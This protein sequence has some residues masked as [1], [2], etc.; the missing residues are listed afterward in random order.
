[1]DRVRFMAGRFGWCDH[2]LLNKIKDLPSRRHT[3]A[4]VTIKG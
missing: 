1:M 3:A 4:S 2:T